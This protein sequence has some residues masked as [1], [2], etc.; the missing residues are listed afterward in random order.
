[1]TDAEKDALLLE[2]GDDAEARE[3][4]ADATPEFIAEYLRVAYGMGWRK[5]L[6]FPEAVRV[7]FDRREETP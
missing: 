6:T 5:G 2:F 7:A 4:W 3:R 1:M